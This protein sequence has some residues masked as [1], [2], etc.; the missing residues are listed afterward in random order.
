MSPAVLDQGFVAPESE[1]TRLVPGPVDAVAR[2]HGDG[3]LLGYLTLWPPGVTQP[4]VSTL[5]ARDGGGNVE[6]CDRAGGNRRCDQRLRNALH[7]RDPGHQR[8]L[9]P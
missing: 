4:L 5:N 3:I 6:R 2:L 1:D 8:V 9:A 7:A